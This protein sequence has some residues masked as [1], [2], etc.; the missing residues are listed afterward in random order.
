MCGCRLAGLKTSA[1]ET[2][3]SL[4]G[5]ISELNLAMKQFKGMSQLLALC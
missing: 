3:A 4:E 1:E 5:Q 2:M